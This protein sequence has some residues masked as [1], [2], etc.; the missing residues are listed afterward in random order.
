MKNVSLHG[1]YYPNNYGDVLILSI[2]SSWIRE[3]TKGDV[4]LPYAT[5]I[6]R[7]S[8]NTP[9]I[10]GKKSII[11]SEYLIFGAGGYMGE[12]PTSNLKWSI[13]FIRNHLKVAI[14]A[15]RH[16][17]PFS[18]NGTGAGPLSNF[19]VRKSVQYIAKNADTI[20]LRDFESKKF[21][22]SLIPDN[23]KII[24]T[25]DV[26]LS[27]KKKDL[28]DELL[29]KVRTDYLSFEGEKVGI[30][31]GADRLNNNNVQI[32]VDEV[33]R[34]FTNH[35]SL[36]PV[37][38]IDNDN[39]VQ[40]EASQY[41]NEKIKHKAVVYKHKDVWETT[42]LL[43]ELDMVLTNK[44][45]IGIVSY[46]MGNVPISFPYHTKTKRFYSQIKLD[47]LCCPISEVEKYKVI[48][49]LEEVYNDIRNNN[50]SKYQNERENMEKKAL[51]NKKVLIDIFNK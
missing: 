39:S 29:E 1:A 40:N 9:N 42:A 50:K 30:H 15:K 10:S 34:F 51:K 45:H 8:L 18:I 24:E 11:D 19:F 20:T 3:I 22:K 36:V 2:Q 28:D 31:I 44:L 37:L 46:A 43:A 13:N 4:V 5:S 33:I 12:P 49:I 23:K 14:I 17:V 35:P 16:G 21:M 47:N 25:A 6:Y 32:I 38:I 41:I 48:N 27:L 7:K 26:A